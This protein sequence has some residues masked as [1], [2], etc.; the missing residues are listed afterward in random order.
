MSKLMWCMPVLVDINDIITMFKILRQENIN[1]KIDIEKIKDRFGRERSHKTAKP[2]MLFFMILGIVKSDGNVNNDALSITSNDDI[3][4]NISTQAY[5]EIIPFKLFIDIIRDF[6]SLNK[7][8]LRR[9]LT[10]S[11]LQYAQK[12]NPD[13][14]SKKIKKLRNK[15]TNEAYWQFPAPS[16]S[17]FIRIAK[18]AGIIDVEKKQIKFLKFDTIEKVREMS[19]NEFERIL[20]QVYDELRKKSG[21]TIQSIDQTRTYMLEKFGLSSE[22]FDKLMEEALVTNPKIQDFR[23]AM[24]NEKGLKK[25]NGDCVFGYMIRGGC[26]GN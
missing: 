22:Q 3:L 11:L 13:E 2:V 16:F 7:D 20:Y 19:Y 6:G 24:K 23:G 26:H 21:T 5:K 4:K 14:Y 12:N 15:Y 1:G 18:E 17:R 8:D 9:K 25:Q 10:S